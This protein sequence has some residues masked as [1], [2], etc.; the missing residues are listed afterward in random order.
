MILLADAGN[1]RLKWSIYHNG[2]RAKQC[3]QDYSQASADTLLI[4]LLT[5]KSSPPLTKLVLV[6]VLGA[7]FA[8]NMQ[9]QC[10]KLAITLQIIVSQPAAYGVKNNYHKPQ[11]LGADRFVGLIAAHHLRPQSHCITISCGTA[12]TID[13][14]TAQGEHL[15]GLILPGLQQFSDQLIKKAALLSLEKEQKI[16]LFANNTTDALASGRIFGLVEAINGISSRM[17]GKLL[18]MNHL[19]RGNQHIMYPVQIIICGGDAKQL[20]HYLDHSIQ[21]EDDWL[22]QGLQVIADATGAPPVSD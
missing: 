19:V 13:A 18:E 5:K 8:E 7:S 6:S 17:K 16:T 3:A 4:D 10:K 9:T 21:R 20:H 1:S 12:V 11:R 15:G 22:M 2:K 14:L